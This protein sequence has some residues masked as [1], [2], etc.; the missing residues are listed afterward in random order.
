MSCHLECKFQLHV[1]RFIKIIGSNLIMN[2]F[3][4]S[5][6]YRFEVIRNH[7]S[8]CQ[9]CALQLLI[10]M[11]HMQKYEMKTIYNLNTQKNTTTIQNLFTS[12][13]TLWLLEFAWV[14]RDCYGK[15]LHYFTLYFIV[16]L[17]KLPILLQLC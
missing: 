6:V 1:L 10:V 9:F 13:Y 7:I 5:K 15:Q 14:L 12:N 17:D 2:N 11:M 3:Q 4:L 16:V 8:N